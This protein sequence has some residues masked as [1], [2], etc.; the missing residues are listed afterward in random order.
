[1]MHAP[2]RP[3]HLVL[4]CWPRAPLRLALTR[5]TPRRRPSFFR[6]VQLDDARRRQAMLGAT[7]RRQ[8]SRTRS[9]ASRRWCWPLR[10]GCDE[11]AHVLLADPGTSVDAQ[12]AN[13]NTALM[14]AAFK[15]N[16][17]AFE[18]LL[19]KGAAVNRRAGPPLH[20]AAAS[21]DDDIAACCWRAARAS[22]RSR[23]RPA[24]AYTPLMMAA[25]EGHDGQRRCS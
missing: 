21:G 5:P 18:A 14:M 6:A 11:G 17:P 7:V 16:R 9:A 10:E 20:Y 19:A 1:M 23:P 2:P 3:R 4:A 24:A 15:R 12:A 13:G 25:R 22:T 8:R